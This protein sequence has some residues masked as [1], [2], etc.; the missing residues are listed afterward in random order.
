MM[1]F[2]NPRFVA[3]RQ[4][5]QGV[6]PK[7]PDV[8]TNDL[9]TFHRDFISPPGPLPQRSAKDQAGSWTYRPRL[10]AEANQPLPPEEGSKPSL[11]YVHGS[12]RSGQR[13]IHYVVRQ[14]RPDLKV[15]KMKPTTRKE[16]MAAK[17][18]QKL[19]QHFA[20]P[21]DFD[22]VDELEPVASPVERAKMIPD[23][24]WSVYDKQNHVGKGAVGDVYAAKRKVR[25]F[26]TT[27]SANPAISSF[28]PLSPSLLPLPACIILPS[29]SSSFPTPS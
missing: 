3:G 23:T 22:A 15:E 24:V 19:L 13:Q 18:A 10:D 29:L 20:A 4:T 6:K 8:A 28:S 7:N 21:I 5:S 9:G 17:K 26:G 12:Q 14:K 1:C 27:A 25:V 11:Q 2:C 16:A